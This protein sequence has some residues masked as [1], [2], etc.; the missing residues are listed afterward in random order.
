MKEDRIDVG[1]GLTID[2]APHKALGMTILTDKDVA[3]R[4]AINEALKGLKDL[5]PSERSAAGKLINERS[6][7]WKDS[8]K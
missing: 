1:D 2:L 8:L 6:R 7:I 4:N 3:E 5:P